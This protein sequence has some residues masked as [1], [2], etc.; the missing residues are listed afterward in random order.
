MSGC[1]NLDS[2][3]QYLLKDC[4]GAKILMVKLYDKDI[5]LISRNGSHQVGSRISH[6]VGSK[7]MIN[8][9]ERRVC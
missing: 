4:D 2:C 5:D 7:K 9:L 3:F 6:V 8:E 1:N